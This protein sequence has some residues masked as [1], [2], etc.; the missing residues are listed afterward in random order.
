M[1]PYFALNWRPQGVK[2]CG[3]SNTVC[4]DLLGGATYIQSTDFF[5]FNIDLLLYSS[6][7][8]RGSTHGH[9]VVCYY[10]LTSKQSTSKRIKAQ[11]ESI[12]HLMPRK[13][14]VYEDFVAHRENA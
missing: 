13:T 10:P 2:V 11:R 12:E 14:H 6:N 1:C 5:E 4:G 3:V 8:P 9:R 7:T